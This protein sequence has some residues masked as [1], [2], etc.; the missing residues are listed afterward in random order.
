MMMVI[1][2]MMMM[3][4]MVIPNTLMHKGCTASNTDNWVH[5]GGNTYKGGDG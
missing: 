5:P 3:M 4:V 2:I 1:I